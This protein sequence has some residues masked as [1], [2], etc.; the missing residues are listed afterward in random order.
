M[1]S[2][3]PAGRRSLLRRSPLDPW[4]LV[5]VVSALVLV[6]NG[7]VFAGPASAVGFLDHTWAVDKQAT[8]ASVTFP[9]TCDPNGSLTGFAAMTVTWTKNAGSPSDT[10][11]NASAAIDDVEGITGTGL[12][13]ST[14]GFTGASGSFDG[15]YLA[16]T[17]TTGNVSWTS[18]SQTSSGSVTFNHTIYATAATN[19]TGSLSDTATLTGSDGF[20]TTGTGSVA[21]TISALV[22]LTITKTIPDVVTGSDTLTF[23]FH[24]TNS[25]DVEA[26]APTITFGAGETSKSVEVT[27]LA[28]DTYN[29]SEDTLPGWQ[30]Q[31]DQQVSFA[32]VAGD[33]STC[34]GGVQFDNA[35]ATTGT[36]IVRKATNPAAAPGS[37]TFSGDAAGVIG[38]GGTITV[39]NL[40]PDTYTSTESDPT[41]AFDLTG[42]SCNDGNSANPSSGSGRTATFKL[43]AGETVTCTFTNRQRGHARVVKTV[44]NVAPSGGQ[45]FA[46]QLR[47]GATA[48]A[49]GTIIESSL[50]NTADGGVVNFTTN[51]VPGTSYQLCEQMMPGWLT[52]LGPPIFS[53][54]NPSG[55][56]SVL[57]T[58]FT[59]TPGQLKVFK[60]DNSPPP[61]GGA[62]SVGFWKNWASCAKSSTSKTPV[63]DQTLLAAANSGFAI[64]VGKVVLDPSVVGRATACSYAVNLLNKS[65][66]AGGTRKASDPLFNLAAHLVAADLNVAAGAGTCAA[67]TA[68]ITQAQALLLKYAFDGNVYSPK[69]MKSD[70]A[71][72][73]PLATALDQYNNDLLC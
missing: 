31:S 66:I 67:A 32:L 30:A 71:L 35:Q 20:T 50:A 23:T 52:S 19:D 27:G 39:N 34:S 41:P 51:L 14:D 49:G 21:V 2:Q 28:E 42:I 57:C 45:S 72:A 47:S 43:E 40:A 62:M 60:I 17:H 55:D 13:F 11:K 1:R 4:R 22:R 69:L 64:T 36:I 46:F 26:A 8:P 33:P 38:D 9:D 18:D 24:V 58:D 68:P 37:F 3:W 63:L 7:V 65:T 10:E 16:G 6:L 56:N 25:S 29:V 48:S 70:A 5:G 59:V 73:G 12:A 15:G 61:G 44:N 54:Y 53:V